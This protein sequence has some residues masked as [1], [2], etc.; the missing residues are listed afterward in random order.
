MQARQPSQHRVKPIALLLLA[1]F[2]LLQ[3]ELWFSEGGITSS[4]RMRQEIAEQEQ[5]N[6]QLKV[7]NLALMADIKELKQGDQAVEE[8]AR[9]ELG[10]V[11][12][13]ETFYQIVK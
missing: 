7:R 12:K 10:M 5:K 6:A 2:L 11:K 4:L 9:T 8:R 1:L 13:G 3:Y